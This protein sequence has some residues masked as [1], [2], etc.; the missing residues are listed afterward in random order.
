MPSVSVTFIIPPPTA[1]IVATTLQLVF[2][3]RANTLFLL[4]RAL[5]IGFFVF[6]CH[7]PLLRFP[8][9]LAF[10]IRVGIQLS[11]A[12]KGTFAI[13]AWKLDASF[14]NGL[15][16]ANDVIEQV[17][18]RRTCARAS[19]AVDDHRAGQNRLVRQR[20]G[21]LRKKLVRSLRKA[22][23]LKGCVFS[24]W[25][26]SRATTVDEESSPLLKTYC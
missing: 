26:S 5:R 6:A 2:W 22:I 16:K 20:G 1:K 12:R 8:F 25:S 9:C 24:T 18:M 7:F 15:V 10:A 13:P 23:R 11:L 4:R 17:S 3:L 21:V 14:R 19:D